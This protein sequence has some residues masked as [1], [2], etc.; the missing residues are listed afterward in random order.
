MINRSQAKFWLIAYLLF[1]II[2]A[3]FY[4]Q[5]A[6][7]RLEPY[8]IYLIL[9]FLLFLLPNLNYFNFEKRDVLLLLYTVLCCFGLIFNH[10][11]A[12]LKSG[13][14]FFLEVFVGYSVGLSVGARIGL[15]KSVISVVLIFFVLLIPFAI[16]ESN[17]GYRLFHVIAG[18]LSGSEY[19]EYLGDSYYRRGVHRASTVF[20]HPILYAICCAV[21]VPFVFYFYKGAKRYLALIGIA[22]GLYASMTS[23]AILMVISQYGLHFL[24]KLQRRFKNIFSIVVYLSLGAYIFLFFASNRGAVLLFISFASLNPQTAYVRYLQWQNASDDISRNFWWGIG[25]NDWT[26]PFWMPSSI[27]SYWLLAMLQNGVFAMVALALFFITLCKGFWKSWR[28]TGNTIYFMF[29]TVVFSIIFAGFTVD[30]F[31]RAQLFIFFLLGCMASF[32]KRGKL[33]K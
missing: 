30:F 25:L 11:A 16:L 27:D 28:L 23:A 7:I 9:A 19:V 6:G 33:I 31:D 8:R 32:L 29:F 22:T 15:F 10:G 14:I 20:S 4:F 2:P 12:G 17:T 21:V 1:M 26:R 18:E 3:E 24:R 5:L 13:G